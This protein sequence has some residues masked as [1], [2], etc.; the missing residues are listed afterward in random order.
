MT[1]L[2]SLLFLVV[3]V[4]AVIGYSL[5]IILLS[6]LLE[7]ESLL[8][9]AASWSRVVLRSLKGL[10]GL[11][12]RLSGIEN[13]PQGPCILM[14]KHQSAWETIAAPGVIPRP[15]AW[16][17]KRELMRVPLF[18]SAL[19]AFR[20]IAIDRKAGRQAMRQ[21]LQEGKAQLE[22]GQSILVFPEGTRVAVGTAAPFN[23][24]GALL[25]EKSGAPVLPIAHNAGVF[26]K[27][28]GLRKLPGCIDMVIGPPIDPTGR[29]A[30]EI[31][32]LVKAWIDETVDALPQ[33]PTPTLAR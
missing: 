19:R 17:L 6:R 32:A 31:N 23:I 15:Q 20:P 18:G 29:S 22:Q 1:T 3:L 9:L 14:A 8:N 28:R 12:Y 5:A 30:K 24:G 16:V 21:L 2:R 27:R 11:D 26:W 25:A 33:T 4:F 13:L 10:C 7:R